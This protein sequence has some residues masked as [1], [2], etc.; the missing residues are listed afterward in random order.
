MDVKVTLEEIYQLYGEATIE[1]AL[2]RRENASLKNQVEE[3][4]KKA[5]PKD[6]K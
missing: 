4:E 1:L 6:G 3:L 2:L 5:K